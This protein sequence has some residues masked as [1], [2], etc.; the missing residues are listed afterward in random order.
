MQ[1]PNLLGWGTNARTRRQGVV[2]NLSIFSCGVV[3]PESGA[4]Q[5]VRILHKIKESRQ[6]TVQLN[7]MKTPLT[8]KHDQMP[9]RIHPN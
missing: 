7:G 5:G 9:L 1:M 2:K 8:Q 6:I 3:T 4:N